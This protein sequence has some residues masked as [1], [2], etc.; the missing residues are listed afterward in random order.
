MKSYR[1]HPAWV[2]WLFLAPFLG[3]FT[4]FIGWPLLRSLVLAFEQTYGPRT[5]VFV[6]FLNFRGVWQ[7]PWFW[8]AVGN[9]LW[10][11]GGILL[12]QIPVAL[13]LAL[14]L[15]RPGL[16]GRALFRLVF[17]SPYVVGAVFV[18]TLF[19]LLLE[20]RIG[21]VNHALHALFLRWDP[22]FPWLDQYVMTSL[23]AASVWLSTGFNLA[24]LLAALQNVSRELLDAAA[25]DGAGPWHRFWHVTL[26]EIRPVLNILILLTVTSGL[27]LFELPFILYN[28]TAGNGPNS[29]ALTVVTYLYQTGF[30]SGNLGY[31]SAIGWILTLTLVGLALLHRRLSRSEDYSA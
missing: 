16:R 9:T 27:Q 22:D 17:F 1:P 2:P 29:Q 23:I 20:K 15:N 12:V 8:T 10:F 19:A 28:D 3:L 18:S 5:R 24:Y 25:I 26:P 14:L 6:G 31:A 30:I 13:G 11:A 4:T 21:L 7:D